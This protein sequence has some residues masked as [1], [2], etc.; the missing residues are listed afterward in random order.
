[1]RHIQ[2]TKVHALGNDLLVIVDPSNSTELTSEDI[3][4]LCDRHTGIGADGVVRAV[5]SVSIPEG[6]RALAE[7]PEAE[8]FMDYVT[9]TGATEAYSA[10][11]LRAMARVLTELSLAELPT[12]ETLSIGTR[13][14]VK[15]VQRNST[16]G[17]QADIGRWRLVGGEP[18]VHAAGLQVARPGLGIEVG[19]PYVVVALSSAEELETLDLREA[20]ETEPAH[21]AGLSIAFVVPEDPLVKNGVGQVRMRVFERDLG[22][23]QSSGTGAAA[24]ALAVRHWAGEG[25]PHHWRVASPGGA[26][27]VRMF[28][29]EEGE[30]LGEAGPAMVVFAGTTT[31]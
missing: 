18:L 10:N 6:E 23:T 8:W 2:F 24:V 12:G 27:Q 3:A 29:T 14:G 20:P 19:I 11:G 7:V 13:V 21:P 16:G 1:M 4:H 9:A 28:P 26:M 17:F 5:R 31:L 30:H 22:E 25:A 15:D